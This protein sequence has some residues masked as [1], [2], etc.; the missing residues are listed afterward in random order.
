MV[1]QGKAGLS[2]VPQTHVLLPQHLRALPGA[3]IPI[4]VDGAGSVVPQPPWQRQE[5]S[6]VGA[7]EAV[8][9]AGGEVGLVH[10]LHVGLGVGAQAARRP[11]GANPAAEH[12]TGQSHSQD[13]AP[14]P[15]PAQ[16]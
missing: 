14:A 10:G 5:D 6:P 7:A 4:P 12:N 15:L 3:G 13:T 9:L 2:W 8:A 1:L 16:G 11:H